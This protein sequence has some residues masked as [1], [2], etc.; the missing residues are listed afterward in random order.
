[1]TDNKILDRLAKLLE[2][3][4]SGNENEAQVAAERAAELMTKY[5]LEAADVEMRLN[6]KNAK[7]EVT[8]ARVD[9]GDDAAPSR[10]ENWHKSLLASLC[11]LVGAHPFFTGRG[12]YATFSMIGPS[13]A[14]GTTRYMYSFLERQINRLSR[15]ATRERGES[16]AWR[17]SYAIG[18]VVRV[19]E[20]LKA[21]KAT[22]MREA[23][24]TAM[25]LVDK[26]ALAVQEE[27]NKRK[28]RKAKTGTRKR[29]D[30]TGYG[31]ADGGKVDIGGATGSLG[32]GQKTLK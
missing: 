3:S 4:K 24:S 11:E 22:A 32:A 2:L 13:S 7:I 16:N 27:V 17:R 19:H 1:M 6:G 9:G 12:K 26:T 8:T 28:F 14:V 21:G 10:V 15:Q 20:R 23:T 25:V 30:A 29:G 5:H 31:Y 18:M